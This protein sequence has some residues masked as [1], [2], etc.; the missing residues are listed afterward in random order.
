VL[1]IGIETEKLIREVVNMLKPLN[2][3]VVIEPVEVEK[4]TASGIILT[5]D[6]A[7]DTYA[8]GVVVAVGPGVAL[9]Q[10]GHREMAVNVGD[11]VIYQDYSG[12]PSLDHEGK[13]LLIMAEYNI[14]AIVE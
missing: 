14:S 2:D 5:G 4:K 9:D 7:V 1:K 10:G 8:E 11:R 3:N 13:K 6:V 12:M